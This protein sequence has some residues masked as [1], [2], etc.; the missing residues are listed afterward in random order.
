MKTIDRLLIQSFLPPFV[1]TFLI[2]TFVLLIQIL[3]VYIDDLAGKGLS[4]FLITELLAYKCVS[5][6]P[7]ALPLAM[8]ISSVM[9]L[10]NLAEHYEL[11]SLKSAGISLLRVMAPMIIF[12][13]MCT[14][15]SYYCSDYLIPVSNLKFGSRM[16]DIQRQKPALRLEEGVFN[17]DFQGFAIRIG[18]KKGDGQ[19]IGNV[20]IYDHK[21]SDEGAYSHIN[22]RSGRM[23]TTPDQKR[24]VM[25]LHDG[26]QY[27]EPRP[28]GRGTASSPFIRTNFKTWT[29]AFDL[30]EFDL[31]RTNEELFKSNRSMLSIAQLQESV[32]SMAVQ[33]E[34][35]RESVFKQLSAYISL[36]KKDTASVQ[37]EEEDLVP[38]YT[39]AEQDTFEPQ[40][41]A[42]TG[43]QAGI[44]KINPGAIKQ[45]R[46]ADT[47]VNNTSTGF[48][49]PVQIPDQLVQTFR[50]S[51][52]GPV[53]SGPGEVGLM[54]NIDKPLA[55]Y[56]SFVETFDTT[57]QNRLIQTGTTLARSL[58]N[59]AESTATTLARM[60]KNRVKFIYELHTKYSFAAMCIVFLFIGAPMGAIVRKGGFGFPILISTIFFVLFI[61]LTIFCRKIAEAFVTPAQ[62]AAWIPCMIFIPIGTYLTLKAMNDS[63]IFRFERLNALIRRLI[64]KKAAV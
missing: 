44:K 46:P 60:K 31:Q 55:S 16:Y 58:L 11:S 8:L 47:T 34:E 59:Q 61:I 43:M 35:R 40:L 27:V 26:H 63:E 13:A 20:I 32:D 1:V 7:M 57:H 48:S 49:N 21:S 22:A 15:L 33:I 51:L 10:G 3:W 54:Q 36:P 25:K 50:G 41:F 42:D 56:G 45:A 2:A 17:D 23:F 30:S 28:S 52:Q 53:P 39:P 24:F 64:P 37:P 4:I 5:L 12:G 6:V 18:D 29:R 9:V 38:A 62:V 19:G 14:A